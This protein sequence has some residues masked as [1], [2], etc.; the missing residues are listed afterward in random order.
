MTQSLE[1]R[2]IAG[3]NLG[4]SLALGV[5][6]TVIGSGDESDLILRDRSVHPKHLELDI[7]LS[8]P[9]AFTVLAKPLEGQT[10]LD[11]E[12][13]EAK[14]RE[15]NPGQVI[16]LGFSAL[17]YGTSEGDFE[18]AELVPL[19]YARSLAPETAGTAG[20]DGGAK[21]KEGAGEAPGEAPG[22]AESGQDVGQAG[23][24]GPSVGPFDTGESEGR[25]AAV[26]ERPRKKSRIG[27]L[28]LVLV[29]I[30]LALL[31]FGP[32]GKDQLGEQLTD[33]QA[34]L[35]SNG[36]ESLEVARVGSGLEAFGELESDAELSRLVELVKGRPSKVFLRITVKKDL[37]EAG[38]QALNSYGFYPSLFFDTEGRPKVTVYMLNQAVEDRAFED[39]AEDVPALDP[40][41]AVIHREDLEPILLQELSAAGMADIM[42]TFRE[43]LLELAVPPGFE[44]ARALA[45]TFNKIAGRM[46]VPVVYTLSTISDEGAPQV[47]QGSGGLEAQLPLPE[48]ASPVIAQ[49]EPG[50]PDDPATY[51]DVVGVTMTPMRFI[52][53]RDGQKLFEGSTLPGGWVI[54]TIESRSLTLA[55]GDESMVVVLGQ[56]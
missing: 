29:A 25:E 36:F 47:I 8:G 41:K 16:S 24:S 34:L 15:V 50:N 18:G 40:V 44:N 4:A 45:Q 48:P 46:G 13:L 20:P 17:V 33:L 27:V 21:E 49:V 56:E 42:V 9:G 31:V 30:A 51:L 12:V 54:A 26:L 6:K 7:A 10:R 43:G 3:P 37:L 14:G 53:T 39:L 55:R 35:R 28:G 23:E 5:G 1:W 22:E 32:A 11:G 38:R 2:V 52:S 19:A